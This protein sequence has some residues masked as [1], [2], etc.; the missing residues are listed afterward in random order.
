[1]IRHTQLVYREERPADD[2]EDGILITLHGY[3]AYA[4]QLLPL[5]KSLSKNFRT[6]ALEAPRPSVVYGRQTAGRSWY[7]MQ[8]LIQPE[9]GTF[10]DTFLQV[11]RFLLDVLGG[12]VPTGGNPPPIF[13]FAFDQGASLALRLSMLWPDVLSGVISICGLVPKVPGWSPEPTPMEGLPVLFIRDPDDPEISG[14]VAEDSVDQ[15]RSAGASVSMYDAKDAREL[16]DSLADI[17]N[18]WLDKVFTD[19]MAD[20]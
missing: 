5:A 20:V 19:R 3:S 8:G 1:M 7:A 9:T 11:E 18:P 14:Q 6:F 16:P 10:G 4:G 2:T 13:L 15:L 12:T 17:I